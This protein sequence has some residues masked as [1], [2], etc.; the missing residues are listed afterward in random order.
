MAEGHE[1]GRDIHNLKIYFHRAKKYA[2]FQSVE[3]LGIFFNH[4]ITGLFKSLFL[5]NNFL[6]SL[7]WMSVSIC[8]FLARFLIR[9]WV[10]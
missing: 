5:Q 10:K 3:L 1:R 4:M 8:T 7:Y 6:T 9:Y 2:I